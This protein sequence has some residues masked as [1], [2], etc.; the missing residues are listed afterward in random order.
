M[1]IFSHIHINFMT[2]EKILKWHT[3]HIIHI[4]KGFP[5]NVNKE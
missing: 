2:L 1:K 3:I 5:N 4:Q